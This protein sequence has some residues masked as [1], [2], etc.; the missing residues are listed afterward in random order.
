MHS[1][2]GLEVVD[3]L[4]HQHDLGDEGGVVAVGQLQVGQP[5]LGG[6]EG[7]A[8]AEVLQH[9]G[10][11]VQTDVVALVPGQGVGVLQRLGGE[12]DGAADGASDPLQVMVPPLAEPHSVEAAHRGGGVDVEALVVGEQLVVVV[13]SGQHV[14]VVEGAFRGQ[15]A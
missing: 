11:H 10:L 2:D 4:A 12:V 14:Q 5:L 6:K 9:D 15:S 3:L 7:V 1:D 13:Q 8:H